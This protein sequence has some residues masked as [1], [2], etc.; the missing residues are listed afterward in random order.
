MEKITRC[1]RKCELVKACGIKLPMFPKDQAAVTIPFPL[2]QIV[3]RESNVRLVYNLCN[4][5]L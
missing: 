1:G 5:L 4:I 3:T 2:K